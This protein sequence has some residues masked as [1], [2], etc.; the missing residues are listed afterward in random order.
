M[1]DWLG[2]QGWIVLTL[3]GMLLFAAATAILLGRWQIGAVSLLTLLFAMAPDALAARLSIT[4]PVPFVVATTVFIFASLFM[5]EVFDF[6]ERFW[7]WDIV[8]HASSATGFGL[9]GFLFVFMLFEG[10]RF[11]APPSAIAFIAFCVAMTAGALWEVFEFAMDQSF[12][13]NMQKSGLPDTMGDLI[14]DTIGALI[15]AVSGYFYLKAPIPEGL[16]IYLA[17]F[18]AMNK[19]LYQK[20]KARL[21]R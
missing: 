1:R 2:R 15:G 8:L 20:S 17:Q 21:K 19:R 13:L 6:Y 7:W 9:I 16:G 4:L 3:W 12:G 5:G 18:V 14:T 11:A 10:D